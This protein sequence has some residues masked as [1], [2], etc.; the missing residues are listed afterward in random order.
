MNELIEYQGGE[1]P[2]WHGD[3]MIATLKANML[4]RV[5][6]NEGRAIF[7]ERLHLNQR[8]RDIAQDQARRIYL[9]INDTPSVLMLSRNR[10]GDGVNPALAP[11][12]ACHQIAP[13]VACDQTGPSLV[14]VV[15]RPV[16]SAPGYAYSQAL[17]EMGGA[18]TV[19]RLDRYLQDVQG[20]A[21]GTTMPQPN[22]DKDG[23]AAV[24][25]ALQE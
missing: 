18:W 15:S 10:E 24:L 6:V 22:L 1:F 19:G 8:L 13:G 9:K 21:L 7:V 4:M 17:R 5:R 2:T 14:G 3:L 12:A 20:F 16:W 25:Q 11:C 23:I